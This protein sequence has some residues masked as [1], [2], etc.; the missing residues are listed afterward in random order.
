MMIKIH[1]FI[2]SRSL[3][4]RLRN[5]S[6]KLIKEIKT[7]ILYSVTFYRQSCR[8]WENVGKNILQ[9]GR[10]QKTKWR[11]PIACWTLKATNTHTK[12]V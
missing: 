11:M 4:L 5:V 8:L 7:R 3:L 9:R 2:T 1:F 12:V 6:D 10:S